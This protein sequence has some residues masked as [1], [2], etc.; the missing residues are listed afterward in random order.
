MGKGEKSR[1]K[2]PEVVIDPEDLKRI[3]R[4]VLE[5]F[6]AAAGTVYGLPISTEEI[7]AQFEHFND[8]PQSPEEQ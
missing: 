1:P 8:Q 6:S 4:S 3:G 7:R 2:Q 5:S